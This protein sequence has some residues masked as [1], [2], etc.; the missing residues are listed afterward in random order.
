MRKKRV[1]RKLREAEENLTDAIITGLIDLC[2]DN[3][4]VIAQKDRTLWESIN[5]RWVAKN[6]GV[7]SKP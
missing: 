2:H 1:K 4:L 5:A 6:L 3:G 7:W